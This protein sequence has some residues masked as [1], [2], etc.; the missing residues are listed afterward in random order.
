VWL[1]NASLENYLM[2]DETTKQI[3]NLHKRPV[4]LTRGHNPDTHNL[5]EEI[6][7]TSLGD[8]WGVLRTR[9]PTSATTAQT[10]N[11]EYIPN[12]TYPYCDVKKTIGQKYPHVKV[13]PSRFWNESPAKDIADE[14]L[15]SLSDYWPGIPI[16]TDIVVDNYSLGLHVYKNLEARYSPPDMI[17]GKRAVNATATIQRL[18]ELWAIPDALIPHW[19][20]T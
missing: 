18:V 8:Y 10:P 12:N 16:Q 19:R 4:G 3:V 1:V 2:I 20:I 11:I 14:L 7:K 9:P 5:L 6:Q 17:T 13:R 15:Y